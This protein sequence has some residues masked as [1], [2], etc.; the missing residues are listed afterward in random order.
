MKVLE[1]RTLETTR[2]YLKEEG[3]RDPTTMVEFNTSDTDSRKSRPR[4]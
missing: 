3:V 2:D 1:G 4:W